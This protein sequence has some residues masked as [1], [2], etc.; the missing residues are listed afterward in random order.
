[1]VW[2]GRVLG[3][4]SS[5]DVSAVLDVVPPELLADPPTPFVA[6]HAVVALAAAGDCH[7]LAQ[8][9]R[10]AAARD[11]DVFQRTVVPLAEAFSDL[12]HGDDDRAVDGLLA[13]DGLDRLGGSA[14]QRDIVE[15][16]L[17]HGTI[18]AG[19]LDLADRL[20]A[21]R[22]ARRPSPRDEERR[23]ALTGVPAGS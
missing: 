10:S 9:R 17:L 7:G 18:R 16:T 2:R 21:T 23:A 11:H 12:V 4:W 15:E 3:A 20:L 13:L 8:L 1:M 5:S 22:L 6:L 14:A 19:R